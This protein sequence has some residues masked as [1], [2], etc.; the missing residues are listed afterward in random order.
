M[1]ASGE[2]LPTQSAVAGDVEVDA[3]VPA[4]LRQPHAGGAGGLCLFAIVH[5][6][7][8]VMGVLSPDSLVIPLP[9]QT[10]CQ[11]A[12]HEQ[13]ALFLFLITNTVFLK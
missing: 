7:L 10:G 5:P 8:E 6:A 1:K 11:P 4:L 9:F 13:V 12:R 3:P 2:A